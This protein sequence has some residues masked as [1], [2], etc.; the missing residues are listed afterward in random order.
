MLAHGPELGIE[1]L[2]PQEA[3]TELMPHWYGARFGM[4]LLRSLGLSSFFLQCATL[5]NKITVCRLKRP[6]SLSALP[7]VAQ[8]VEEHLARDVHPAEA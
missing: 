2:Q 7:D 1:P 8:L 3:L 4:G 6:P 5:A